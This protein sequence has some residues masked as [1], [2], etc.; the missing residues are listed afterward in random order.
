MKAWKFSDFERLSNADIQTEIEPLFAK[1]ADA[2]TSGL[3]KI[4]YGIE[5]QLLLEELSRRRQAQQT[6]TMVWCTYAIT[7]MTLLILLATGA[8]VCIQRQQLHRAPA[9]YKQSNPAA[10]IPAVVVHSFLFSSGS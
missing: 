4:P 10:Q 3:E 5:A 7:F 8:Q 1:V 9:R 2:Q 6:R